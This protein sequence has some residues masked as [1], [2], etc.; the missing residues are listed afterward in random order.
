MLMMVND[1]D[2]I[3]SRRGAGAAM[4]RSTVGPRLVTVQG[5]LRSAR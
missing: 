4:A 1:T 5:D 3:E 2:E